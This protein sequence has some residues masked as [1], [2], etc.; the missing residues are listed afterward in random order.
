M[1]AGAAKLLARGGITWIIETHSLAL[2]QTCVRLL[3]SH[4]LTVRIVSP[5][6]WRFAVPEARPIAHNRWLVASVRGM[7]AR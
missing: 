7:A 2:E 5:A 3:E 6:W 1:L 4:G